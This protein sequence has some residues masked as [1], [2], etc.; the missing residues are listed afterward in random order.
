MEVWEPTSTN[1]LTVF[2]GAM[3]GQENLVGTFKGESRDHMCIEEGFLAAT[4]H[5]QQIVDL[6]SSDWV[7]TISGNGVWCDPE[8]SYGDTLEFIDVLKTSEGGIVSVNQVGSALYA[9][10]SPTDSNGNT[11]LFTGTLAG[12]FVNINLFE[13]GLSSFATGIGSVNE[14]TIDGILA[15]TLTF[16]DGRVCELD[17]AAISV[18]LIDK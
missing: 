17:D 13:T 7:V 6:S 15:G 11:Y 16:D 10:E 5:K 9:A 1:Y 3:Q 2:S 18:L 8:L 14:D 4:L 12:S